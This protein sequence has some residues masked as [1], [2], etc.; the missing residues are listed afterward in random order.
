MNNLFAKLLLVAALLLPITATAYDFMVDSLAYNIN[1]DGNSVSVTYTNYNSDF[2]Y[3]GLTEAN[4]PEA[5]TYDSNTYSVTSI[6]GCAFLRCGGLMSVTIPN[7]VTS[8]GDHAFNGCTGLTSIDIKNS[9][10]GNCQFSGCTGLTSITIPNSVTSIGGYAFSGCTGLTSVTIP[11]SV[12]SIGGSA[13]NGCTGL[14][15]IYSKITEPQ[16]VSYGNDIFQGVSTNYCKLYVPKGTSES[17]QFIA[18]WSDFLNILEEGGGTTPLKGD[19]NDD[20]MID[21]E[22][23]NALINII[24]KL[25][26]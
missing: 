6:V 17:Y 10:I 25:A 7:S 12:T 16:N 21:V 2:N 13:F 15:T 20:G 18:P 24:L 9:V 19:M 8:I 23:V 5:V 11:N 22:D 3:S 26:K 1:E 4:I 14:R